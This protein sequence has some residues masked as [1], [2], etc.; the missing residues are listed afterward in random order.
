[1]NSLFSDTTTYQQI[2]QTSASGRH[3]ERACYFSELLSSEH[4]VSGDRVDDRRIV[5]RRQ[6]TSKY[7]TRIQSK[8]LIKKN[9][10]AP[11]PTSQGFSNIAVVIFSSIADLFQHQVV[12]VS[13]L[14]TIRRN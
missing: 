7:G 4:A 11:R 1:M 14:K 3:A 6:R 13:T 2:P 8:P 5:D 10:T 12:D 9:V